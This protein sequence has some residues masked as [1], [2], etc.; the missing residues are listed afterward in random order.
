ME[1]TW[2]PRSSHLHV[3]QVTQ[4]PRGTRNVQ[5]LWESN[6]NR[7]RKASYWGR[8]V[9]DGWFCCRSWT[10]SGQSLSQVPFVCKRHQDVFVL[11]RGVFDDFSSI[12]QVPEKR[13]ECSVL[14]V[15]MLKILSWRDLTLQQDLLLPCWT[16]FLCLWEH[17]IENMRRLL[18]VLLI[19]AFLQTIWRWEAVWIAETI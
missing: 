15:E 5:V 13:K 7:R 19:W 18:N 2:S 10:Q 11:P 14:V 8:A 16:L 3:S 9:P 4:W 1:W 17:P 12:Q 6:L